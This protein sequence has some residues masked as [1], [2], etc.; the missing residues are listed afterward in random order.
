MRQIKTVLFDLGNVLGYINFDAFWRSLGFN[1]MDKQSPCAVRYKELTRQYETGFI[2]T[3]EYLK[4]LYSLFENRFTILQ[5]QQAVESIIEEPVEGMLKLVQ[6]V[7]AKYQTALVSNTN[8]I[9]YKFSVKRFETLRILQKHYLSYQ[10]HV[11]KPADRFYHAIINDLQIKP[12]EMLF[13][14]D[15]Q[16]NVDGAITAGMQAIKFENPAQLE[17]NLKILGVLF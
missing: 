8:E 6:K 15:I 1:E 5:L 17:A 16:I 2:H 14:D 4:K 11:M 10:L 12:A 7:S 3:E 9:H 13:V